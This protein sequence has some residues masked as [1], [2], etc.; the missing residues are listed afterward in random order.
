MEQQQLLGGLR[1]DVVAIL[2]HDHRQPGGL[3]RP[4]GRIDLRFASARV[5]DHQPDEP[6]A[7][8]ETDDQQPDVEFS[9]HRRPV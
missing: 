3:S 4:L 7:Q 1:A 6:G 2:G 8:D 5:H 9:V